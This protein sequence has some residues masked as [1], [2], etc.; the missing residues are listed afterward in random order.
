METH[1]PQQILAG[2]DGYLQR[3][4]DIDPYWEWSSSIRRGVSV[5]LR[6]YCHVLRERRHQ[7]RQTTLLSYFKRNLKSLQLMQRRPKMIHLTPTIHRQGI[8]LISNDY[9]FIFYYRINVIQIHVYSVYVFCIMLWKR[10]WIFVYLECIRLK[11][12]NI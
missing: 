4:G 2:I 6:S 7:A 8:P 12:S 9:V 1:N 10:V 11:S 5:E 3:L